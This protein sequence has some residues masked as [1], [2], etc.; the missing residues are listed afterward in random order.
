MNEL[1]KKIVLSLVATAMLW[2]IVGQYVISD[3]AAAQM[4]NRSAPSIES[5]VWLNSKGLSNKMLRGK[6]YLVEFWTFGCYNCENVEPYVKEW[7]EKYKGQGFEVVS[8]HSPEFS[9]EKDINN[10]R[11]YVIKKQISYPVAIDNDFTIWKRFNNRYWPAMY[12]VDKKGI[13][14]YTHFGEGRYKETEKKIRQL[15]SE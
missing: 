11:N 1:T 12:L 7:H 2:S 4:L 14:R 8:V 13:I 10:V 15:L 3:S 6:V 5:G 9:H